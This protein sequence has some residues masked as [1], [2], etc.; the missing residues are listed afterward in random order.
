[1]RFFPAFGKLSMRVTAIVLTRR[2]TRTPL[3]HGSKF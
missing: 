2:F 1:M 3:Y